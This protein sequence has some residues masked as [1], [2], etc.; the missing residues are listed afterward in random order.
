[1]QYS[2]STGEAQLMNAT[3]PSEQASP[4]SSNGGSASGAACDSE[5]VTKGSNY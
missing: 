2:F 1:M 5:T 4:V 3:G